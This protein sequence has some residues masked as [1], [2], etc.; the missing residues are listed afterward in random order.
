MD[1]IANENR[2]IVEPIKIQPTGKIVIPDSC[3]E[4]LTKGIVVAC[5]N[6]Q[7]IG[8]GDTVFY[9]N[10]TGTD[11]NYNGIH[12]KVFNKHDIF[13]IEKKAKKQ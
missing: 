5:N 8:I 10:Y 12:Y 7:P 13:A 2:V 1:L 6:A 9:G 3:E 11:F 4:I